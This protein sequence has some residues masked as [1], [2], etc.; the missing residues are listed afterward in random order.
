MTSN[1]CVVTVMVWGA[2]VGSQRF[3]HFF[4]LDIRKMLIES[5]MKSALGL[6]HILFTANFAS[7][8]VNQVMATTGDCVFGTEFSA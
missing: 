8:T 1:F 2:V 3:I 6:A 7:K 4:V 5:F